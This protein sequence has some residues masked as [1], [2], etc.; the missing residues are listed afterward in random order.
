MLI[1]FIR[2]GKWLEARAKGKARQ[3]LK[4]L[5]QLQADRARLLIDGREEQVPAID[6]GR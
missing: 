4:A 1:T 5:L 3:A 2:F 6:S